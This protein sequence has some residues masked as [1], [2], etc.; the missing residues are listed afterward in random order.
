MQQASSKNETCSKCDGLHPTDECPHFPKPAEDHSDARRPDAVDLSTPD[1]PPLKVRATRVEQPSDNSC[2]F[3]SLAYG[4]SKAGRGG[5][6]LRRK[7][8]AWLHANSSSRVVG[9]TWGEWIAKQMMPDPQVGGSAQAYGSR[10]R[11]TKRT[12]AGMTV[13]QYVEMMKSEKEWGGAIEFALCQHSE[14]VSVWVFKHLGGNEYKRI[15]VFGSPTAEGKVVSVV[16]DHDQEGRVVHYDALVLDPENVRHRPKDTP[17][18]PAQ[19]CD[20]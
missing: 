13:K 15:D 19:T 1:T 18:G 8:L 9:Q 17:R 14:E 7:L 10:T 3:H 2:L 11:S 16:A 6:A 12:A 4:L 5:P 20:L